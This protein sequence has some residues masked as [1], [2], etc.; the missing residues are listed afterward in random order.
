[1]IRRH[2]ATLWVCDFFLVKT[3]TMRGVVGLYVLFFLHA[4]SRKVFIAGVTAHPDA[5]W[6][7]QQARNLALHLDEMGQKATHL[8]RDR[9]TN[10]TAQFASTLQSEGLKVTKTSVRAPNMNALAERYVQSARQECL[11]HFVF[12][13]EKHLSHAL[14]EYERH[15]NEERPHQGLGNR[16]LRGWPESALAE[17]IRPGDIVCEER[18]GGRVKSYHPDP[19]E[20]G[21]S[22]RGAAAP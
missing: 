13:R 7:V 17:G 22:G 20:P 18:L 21:R 11:D 12:F 5:A 4:G 2:L 8:L 19:R 6:V 15:Y 9:D 14:R 16:P 10:F 3:W 1:F